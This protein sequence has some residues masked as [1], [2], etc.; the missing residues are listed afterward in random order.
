MASRRNVVVT[1]HSRKK[2]E[3]GVTDGSKEEV[4]SYFQGIYSKARQL[5][6]TPQELAPLGGHGRP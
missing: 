4:E 3:W 2:E 5:D 6:R 1:F